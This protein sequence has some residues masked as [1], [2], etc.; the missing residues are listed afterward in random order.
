M[1]AFLAAFLPDEVKRQALQ[2]PAG[3][4]GRFVNLSIQKI[5]RAQNRKFCD[6]QTLNY[7]DLK[8]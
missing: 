8:L 3:M 4:A 1:S 7:C 5:L 6:E 2:V